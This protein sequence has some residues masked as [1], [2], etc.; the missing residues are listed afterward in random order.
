MGTVES[1]LRVSLIDALTGPSRG[2][3][4]SVERLTAISKRNTEQL[5]AM[6]GQMVDAVG[7]GYALWHSLSAPVSAAIDFESAMSDIR[8]VVT[9]DTAES[10][11]KLG[12]S[13]RKM[14]LYIPMAATG[15]AEIIAAAG[16]SGIANDELERFAEI[17][18]KVSVA[19]D[20]GARETGDALA[21]LK[22]AMG[23]TLEQTASL[24]DA[25]NHL[26]NNSAASAPNI[27]EVVKRVAP[28]A[29]TFGFTA[30]QIA[31]IGAT[32]VGSGFEADIAATSI[33]NMGRALTKGA[34]ATKR[35]NA[36]FAQLHLNSK[37]VAKSMQKDAVGTLV[38]VLDRINKLPAA[39]RA[40]AVSDLF[41]DEARALGP[42]ITNSKLLAQVL[43]LVD[44][45]QKYAGSAAQEFDTASRR[46]AFG[47]QIFKNRV[48]D[49]AISVGDALL[50]ALNNILYHL[51]PMVS[52]ISE[53][54]R[55]YPQLTSAI[56]IATASLIGFRIA[57]TAARW[58]GLYAFGSMLSGLV[59]IARM[60]AIFSSIDSLLLVLGA[61]LT[62]VSAPVWLSIAG[63]VAVAAAAGWTLY[64]YW[65]RLSAVVSGI[66]HRIG[67][68]F[69]PA[70]EALQP[71]LGPTAAAIRAMGDAAAWVGEGLAS[72]WNAVSSWLSNLLSPETLTSGQKAAWERAGYD[73]ADA[74]INAIKSAFDGLIQWFAGLPA[75]IVAAIGSIDLSNLIKWPSIPGLGGGGKPSGN[76]G[77]DG[78]RASGGPVFA[79][80]TYL[81][82]EN[83]P[84]LFS[85]GASGMISPNDAYQAAAAGSQATA[86]SRGGNTIS[87][88]ISPSFTIS[89]AG[90]AD[91]FAEIASENWRLR[92]GCGRIRFVRLI[93]S[94][95]IG[96][97]EGSPHW[98][99]YFSSRKVCDLIG[100]NGQFFRCW[101]GNSAPSRDRRDVPVENISFQV[102]K[103]AT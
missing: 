52:N 69:R 66:A 70:L 83:G 49:L 74:M 81:V 34:S 32:M 6:R 85:P 73:F 84:E 40:A 10:F 45:K 80:R 54:A 65:D 17:A 44:E 55:H 76:G 9:F 89:G 86:V 47:L 11:N 37:K 50:P 36:V 102:A 13:I 77:V 87:I 16:Q 63:A 29:K 57:L 91:Q 62:L 94:R 68:E 41:G 19:W 96:D 1:K 64:K 95:Q 25:I 30:E 33:L 97:D 5:S 14:S 100:S 48:N 43:G 71:F 7:A 28:M 35:Q 79:R 99:S 42:L 72:A 4:S 67:D 58:A 61:G 93:P 21:K 3:V 8:K 46:T 98:R 51:G 90:S 38:D 24:A 20:M 18:A 15:I 59:G 26:G 82:G 22:T 56:T 53:L 31:A 92:Q 60:M 103:F 78:A 88:S 2:I 101:C 39:S 23:L 27:L 12:D 75:R